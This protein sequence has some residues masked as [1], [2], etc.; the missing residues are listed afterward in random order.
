FDY[1]IGVTRNK[2]WIPPV[3]SDA[4]ADSGLL[5]LGFRLEEWA[6]RVLFRSVISPEGR[7]RRSRYANVAG[8]IL[9]EE[10]LFLDPEQARRYLESYLR[11]SEI[12]IFWGSVDDFIQELSRK[13]D[14]AGPALATA[15]DENPFF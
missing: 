11:G 10:G 7:Q 12:S 8:Q 6:F 4:L 14:E 15:A 13:W 2:K 1:L 3:V 5:F 9:P